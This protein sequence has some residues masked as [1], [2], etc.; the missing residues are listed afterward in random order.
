VA[1]VMGPRPSLCV[2][3]GTEI[4]V[5]GILE[6]RRSGAKLRGIGAGIRLYVSVKRC[7]ESGQ[8]LKH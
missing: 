1:V 7:L 8:N 3:L 2:R 6:Q 5:K 4:V